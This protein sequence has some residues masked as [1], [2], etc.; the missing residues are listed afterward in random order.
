MICNSDVFKEC[1]HFGYNLKDKIIILPILNIT[2][3][4]SKVRRN[5]FRLSILKIFI[6]IY[7]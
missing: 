5:L 6:I 3:K 4:Y 7:F 1:N 2:F